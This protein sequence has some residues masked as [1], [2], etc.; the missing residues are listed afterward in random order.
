MNGCLDGRNFGTQLLYFE[1]G[2]LH[3][4]PCSAVT[5]SK[6]ASSAAHLFACRKPPFANRLLPAAQQHLADWSQI[7]HEHQLKQSHNTLPLSSLVNSRIN[8]AHIQRLTS[9]PG[10][11]HSSPN[12]PNSQLLTFF[13]V[14]ALGK[15]GEYLTIF[16]S[17]TT[18]LPGDKYTTSVLSR[19][20]PTA[21]LFNSAFW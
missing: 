11:F 16:S 7:Y 4:F 1:L 21:Y 18:A 17:I 13:L 10:C 14:T 3:A 2:I 19:L 9:S 5:D 15:H 12:Q 20:P 6:L 8:Q